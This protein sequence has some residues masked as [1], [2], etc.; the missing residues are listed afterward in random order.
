MKN[1]RIAHSANLPAGRQGAIAQK[2]LMSGNEAM[3]EAAIKAGCYFYAGYPITPQNELP[4]YMS[5]RMREE[6]RVFIQAESEL[7]AINM[8]FG[9]SSA[10]FRA[11]TSSSS[12]GIS[13]KQEGISYLAGAQL[14]AVIINVMRG[15]PG[16]GNIASSQSDYFQATRG[17]G[18]GDYFTPVLAPWSVNEAA[19]LVSLAFDFAD[20]Y[21]TPVL[22]LADAII[23]QM[24]EAVEFTSDN[25]F[26]N[27]L[28]VKD[29]ALTGAKNRP[30][31]I[32]KSFFLK[33]GALEAH[34]QRLSKK[35]ERIKNNEQRFS[36]YKTDDAKYLIVAY[37]SQAR[38]AWEAVD[39][40][41]KQKIKVGL[42]RPI[43]LWP[44]PEKNLKAIAKGIK[45]VLVVEQSLGQMVDDVRLSLPGKDIHFLGRTGGGIPTE[46]VII[47]KIRSFCHR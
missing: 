28:P 15:G 33:E 4:E 25:G 9:A 31:R 27:K 36:A 21:R 12:P 1:D 44:Y 37:G 20:Y 16:L 41:R 39:I 45:K 13:L 38:I 10:G 19:R 2:I 17:G 43:S 11:L 24:M 42:F 18:H 6:H 29:W 23:G 32:V 3:A 34:N 47:K 22:I 46:D 8:V 35:W 14:P 40:L 5:K 26:K 30:S 7:A